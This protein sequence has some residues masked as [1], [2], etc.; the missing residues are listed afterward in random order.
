MLE[1]VEVPEDD[2]VFDAPE[3]NADAFV[4]QALTR[5]VQ[6]CG[7]QRWILAIPGIPDIENGQELHLTFDESGQCENVFFIA[8]GY[9]EVPSSYGTCSVEHGGTINFEMANGDSY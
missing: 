3:F 1:L 8:S 4:V 5:R 7:E 2:D 6:E 9:T